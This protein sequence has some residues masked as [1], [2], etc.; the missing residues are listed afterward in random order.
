MFTSFDWGILGMENIPP[1]KMVEIW[2]ILG[3][4]NIPP[5]YLW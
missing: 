1:I 4:E 5:I 2:G 3:M